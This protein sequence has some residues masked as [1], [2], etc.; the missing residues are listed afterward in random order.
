MPLGIREPVR[1]ICLLVL[2]LALSLTPGRALW[3][4]DALQEGFVNPPDS[5]KPHTWWHWMNGN[6]TKEGITA[7]LE[8][9]KHVGVG[10][11]QIF[12]ADCGIPPGPV[13]FMSEQWREMTKHA[14]T[15]AD[16]LGVELCMHNCAGWS[17]SGGP[18]NTPE[19][20]MQIVV[21]SE[22]KVK[23]P[24]KFSGVLPQPPKKLDCYHNIAVLA[25]K[26]PEGED[27]KMWAFSPKV[28]S[29]AERAGGKIMDA[30]GNIRVSFDAPIPRE[31]EFV[32][33]EFA[34]PFQARTLIIAG[35]GTRSC[36]GS[37]QV[38]DDGQKFRIVRPFAFSHEGSRLAC[39]FEPVSARFYKV[40][41]NRA[42]TRTKKVH[43]TE[44]TLS[45]AVRIDNI[46]GKAA[47]VR[48]DN[49]QPKAGATVPPEAVVKRDAIVDLTSRMQPDGK[50]EWDVPEGDWTL[51]RLGYTPNG[52]SNHPAPKEG[53]G[54]ECDKLSREAMDAH[55]AGMVQKVI[56]DVGPLA[57]KAFNNVLIDS[58]EVGSQNWTPRFREEFQKRRGYDLLTYLPTFTGRVVD[59]PE[60]SERF[61][62]DLRRTIADLFAENYAGR[63]GELCHQHNMRLSIEPYG[64]G[65]FE[66]MSYGG[67][68]D[69]PMGEF[70]A[71]GGASGSCKLASS[72]GHIYGKT[73]IGAESFT[74][75]PE[76]GRWTNDPYSMKAL[77]DVIWSQGVNRFIFHRYAQQPWMDRFP[78]MTMGQWGTHFE[79]T[80]TWWEQGAAWLKY[81]ARSQYLL[82]QGL[83]VGDACYFCGEGAPVGLR[84]GKP[85]L[86]KGYDFDGCN[87]EVILTRMSVKR[88]AARNATD[89]R[90]VLPDGM[91]YRILILPPDETMT[92]TL[93]KKIRQLVEDGATV[94]GPKPFR[95]PS[96]Q[97]Y[98]KCD[99]EVKSLADEVWGNCDG[100]KVTEHAFGEGKVIC[101]KPME[102]VFAAMGVKPD[103]EFAG[104]KKSAKVVYIHRRSAASA[105]PGRATAD[106]DIY[107]VS[108]Q[109]STYEEVECTFRV[110]GK[111][112]ELWNAET[113]TMEKAPVYEEKD[114]R[115][116]IPLRFTP[117]GSAFVVFRE[118]ASGA[119]HVVAVVSKT[120]ETASQPT[121]KLEIRSAVYEAQDGAGSMD[122]TALLAG[123][124]KDGVLSVE[125]DNKTLGRDPASMHVK[126]LRVE[127]TLDGK[128]YQKIVQE[129]ATLEIPDVSAGTEVPAFE[130]RAGADGKTEVT[131][132]RPGVCELKTAAGKTMKA[133]VRD[134]PKPVDVAGPWELRFPPKWGA[135]EKVTL[136]KLISWT[137]HSEA[138][139]RYF[140]G[141]ATYVK[142]IE[143]PAEM[144]GQGKV[145]YLDLGQLKNLAQVS[146]NGVFADRPARPTGLNAGH[147][148]LPIGKNI[149]KDLGIL[150]KPPFLVEIT[151][152]ARAGRNQLEVRITNLW[153]NRLIGDEQLPPDCEWNGKQLAGWPQW[154]LDGKP[155]PTGRLTFTTW[156][157]YEKDSPLLESGLLG[158]VRL[159][160]AVKVQAQ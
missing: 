39:E 76:N 57:G 41:F 94:V 37:L 105:A 61:L 38:S 50:I 152:A 77:G 73:V 46:D 30:K 133:E 11:A 119:D 158:P 21:T 7:D 82:Q 65:P 139:V 138:G 129:N 117:A 110:S 85:E 145:L 155:S 33:F 96:L 22:Q 103:F 18:W 88:Y 102:E 15:E 62:W 13:P 108:N 12:N 101:G 53:T 78:G 43:I 81:V 150:W 148:G 20:G 114:G 95:S 137:E 58:Y 157:H 121:A 70:W 24:S 130:L 3:A 66:D 123:M 151:D 128:P 126:Q 26:T 90:I 83:F 45:P 120:A 131:A 146:V 91:S 80:N 1:M 122:V 67:R 6:V 28:T 104:A 52:R 79:R 135:P 31:P 89:G 87:A 149:G 49:I 93:L 142:E 156:K 147:A 127:Y 141:T 144:V 14:V 71:G 8:A 154:V 68:A 132:W 125:A 92:P 99:D 17:S 75:S 136:E 109:R 60:M 113:G 63:L 134:V 27:V 97:D 2:G 4:A 59:S 100:V 64:N 44:I 55:F 74:A 159:L 118:K 54:L 10:G 160:G 51:L 140:S 19:H 34:Q 84:A 124:M 5:A 56:D 112:P 23:G 153:P 111:V 42:D 72:V 48:M 69:I 107:F 115:V 40:V 98:P 16:R 86:P 47:Y 116:T 9:M 143:I 25:F 106:A 29:S 32:Q 35:S 36:G